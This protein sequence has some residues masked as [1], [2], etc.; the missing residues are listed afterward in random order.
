M[1]DLPYQKHKEL[2]PVIS[3]CSLSWLANQQ[4]CLNMHP[5]NSC[6]S[7]LLSV[8]ETLS[9]APS[10]EQRKIISNGAV[11]LA[12]AD[13]CHFQDANEG[14]KVEKLTPQDEQPHSNGLCATDFVH[15]QGQDSFSN[16][17]KVVVEYINEDAD[18]NVDL[19]TCDD[20][21]YPVNSGEKVPV[22]IPLED[23]PYGWPAIKS[24]IIV[25]FSNVGFFN[26]S[27]FTCQQPVNSTSDLVPLTSIN[28]TVGSSVLL[29]SERATMGHSFLSSLP[30][31]VSTSGLSNSASP[32]STNDC[33]TNSDTNNMEADDD[34]AQEQV[35]GVALHDDSNSQVNLYIDHYDQSAFFRLME[36]LSYNEHIMVLHIFRSW[37]DG[38]KRSRNTTDLGVMFD[39][40]KSLPRLCHLSLSNFLPEELETVT[41]EQWQNPHLTSLRI[42]VCR[43][44]L[45]E[46]LLKSLA[47]IPELCDLALEVNKSSP[48]H[49]VLANEQLQLLSIAGN[50]YFWKHI[51]IVELVH[52]LF[53]TS[54]LKRL[55]L[56]PPMH[57]KTF[58]YLAYGLNANPSIE[59]LRVNVLPGD[60]NSETNE[61][62]LVLSQS[63][64][65]NSRLKS[66]WNTNY[67]SLRVDDLVS[68]SLINTFT[69]NDTIQ[70][71]LMFEEESDFQSTKESLLKDNRLNSVPLLQDFHVVG[72]AAV[73]SLQQATPIQDPDDEHLYLV[74][75]LATD[76]AVMWSSIVRFGRSIKT[77][78]DDF[79][80]LVTDTVVMMSQA[81]AIKSAAGGDVR[82]SHG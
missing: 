56:E 21:V 35:E 66:V 53:Q 72:C 23:N 80:G 54:T 58:Q 27:Y 67:S 48:F 9:Y 7:G 3:G 70:E 31:I 45:S 24:K 28:G 30:G 1:S 8:K 78:S 81:V 55:S 61:A 57:A 73:E 4:L 19:E 79:F 43:G 10:L 25:E 71:F 76:Y 36:D 77:L 16:A 40:I 12:D 13:E 44:G 2:L 14:D 64:L 37:D 82:P 11:A 65:V 26:A 63:L 15:Q 49:H 29:E 42:H 52:G 20:D 22:S 33:A 68:K 5:K 74:N 46:D 41:P 62:I 69:K 60:S 18:G 17:R 51:H 75:S 39:T 47:K 59:D 50:D 6:A 32:T 34:E 38:I